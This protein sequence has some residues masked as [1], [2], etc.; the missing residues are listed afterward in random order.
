MP[1]IVWEQFAWLL[2]IGLASVGAELSDAGE[3]SSSRPA[4]KT[5]PKIV[6]PHRGMMTMLHT[7]LAAQLLSLRDTHVLYMS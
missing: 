5:S 2:L 6:L 1:A 4:R 3:Q 7:G